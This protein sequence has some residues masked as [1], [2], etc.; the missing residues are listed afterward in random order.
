MNSLRCFQRSQWI[1]FLLGLFL[2][3]ADTDAF[4]GRHYNELSRI[5]ALDATKS[6]GKLIKTGDMYNDIVLAKGSPRPVLVFFS[7]PW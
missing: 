4:L 3:I 1:T 6:G 5:S 2:I 7:A